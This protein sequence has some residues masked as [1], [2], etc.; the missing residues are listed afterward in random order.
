[1]QIKVAPIQGRRARYLCAGSGPAVILLHGIGLSG[2]AWL[3]NIEPLATHC[4]VIAPDLLGHGFSDPADFGGEASQVANARHVISLA[5]ALGIDRFAVVGS[6]YGAL[7]ASLV[8]FIRPERVTKLGL[9]GS[10]STF[11]SEEDQAKALR[12]AAALAEQALGNPTLESCRRRMQGVVYDKN[13]VPEELLWLQLAAYALPDRKAA[14]QATIESCIAKMD[15]RSSR[16]LWRLEQIGVPTRVIVGRN[17]IRADWRSHEAGVRRIP[18]AALSIYEQCGHLPFLEHT[19]RF[20]ED[21]SAFLR[22]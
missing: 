22:R 7:V 2:D 11:Q 5:D 21:V 18:N 20:N 8:Y 19:D 13:V 4:L 12:A 16:A 15:D 10:A 1:M 14:Y 9:V 3:R 17:D 6:S